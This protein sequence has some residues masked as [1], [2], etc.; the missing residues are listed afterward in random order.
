[1]SLVFRIV[2]IVA[3][4]ISFLYMMKKI[5]QSKLQIE[6]ALFWIVFSLIV[7]ILAIFPQ[8]AMWLADILGIQS[9][10]NLVYL[11]IIFIL[12][13]KL[14]QDTLHISKL[15]NKIKNLIQHEAIRE[16]EEDKE[17]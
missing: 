13:V 1:M 4:I 11:I 7:I 14:F 9:A 17:A 5:K 6:H 15:E 8:I 3:S 16:Q 12:I 10:V 2:L